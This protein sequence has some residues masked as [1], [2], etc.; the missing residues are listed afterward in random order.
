MDVVFVVDV[1]N[2]DAMFGFNRLMTF[3]SDV[4][5]RFP[6]IGR[7]ATRVAMV[8]YAEHPRIEI[9]LD[10]FDNKDDLQVSINM[11]SELS[12]I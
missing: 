2:S 11:H 3:I 10:D 5:D 6:S 9:F 7:L 8:T 1:L 12:M 4:I